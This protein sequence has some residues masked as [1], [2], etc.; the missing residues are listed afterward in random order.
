[1]IIA[2][3]PIGQTGLSGNKKPC[4]NENI[5]VSTAGP[6]NEIKD[7]NMRLKNLLH[8]SSIS[9]GPSF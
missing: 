5:T 4:A 6:C 1:M 7:L 3:K 9:T 2:N 8:K